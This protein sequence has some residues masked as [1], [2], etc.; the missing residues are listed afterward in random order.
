MMIPIEEIMEENRDLN[1]KNGELFGRI[2][3]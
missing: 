3:V 2:W 1:G